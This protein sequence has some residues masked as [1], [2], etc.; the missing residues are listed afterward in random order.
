ML[1]ALPA[2]ADAEGIGPRV[3]AVFEEEFLAIVTASGP[4]PALGAPLRA[5]GR[6]GRPVT[7]GIRRPDRE[8]HRRGR[9]AEQRRPVGGRRRIRPDQRSPPSIRVP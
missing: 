6:Q 7:V 9:S 8:R 2:P 4:W 5:T 3:D 1:T